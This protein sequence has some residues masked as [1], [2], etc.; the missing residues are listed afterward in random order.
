MKTIK[1]RADLFCKVILASMGI[2]NISNEKLEKDDDVVVYTCDVMEQSKHG[3]GIRGFHL[4]KC[5][6][7][8]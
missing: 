2:S 5:Q 3:N 6:H 7:T 4:F 8:R 1:V